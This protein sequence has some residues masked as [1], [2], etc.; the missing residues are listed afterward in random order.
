MRIVAVG[1]D[2]GKTVFHLVAMGERNRV[3][4]RR[5]FSRQQLLAYTANLE[6]TLIGTEACAGAHF[7]ATA[8]CAQGHD[9]RLMAAQFVKPYRKSNKS[10]FLDAETIADA[11][12]KENMRFVPVKTDEQLDLQAMHR[13]RTRLVQRRTALIN[14]IRGFLLERG[15]IFPAKPI[16]L[17]KQLPGVLE[18][19]TQNLTPRLRWLLSELAEEWKELEARIIA[20]SDAIERI[21]TSDPLCQRLRQIPGFGPLVSTATVAAIGNGSSFRKGRDFAAWLGVVPRQYSTG[22]KTALYGMS[23]R[24]NRYLRQLLIHGA[25]AVLIRVK[26]DTAGLGQWIHKLAERAPRNKVIVAIANK[27][28]RIAWAVLAKGEPYR[29]QPLAAAA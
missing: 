12:Q 16:H 22:G 14:E 26:Y 29:H 1:I 17:R 5:K 11:V 4:V 20:I 7:L 2:L 13:V 23:K 9:V 24:G 27:L 6:P 25:R 19:A 10:D 3:L 15:I 18:D 8:L 21:S 28:A